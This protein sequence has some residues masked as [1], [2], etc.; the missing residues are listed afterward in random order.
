MSFLSKH[1]EKKQKH[2]VSGVITMPSCVIF[3]QRK[4]LRRIS[5][6]GVRLRHQF[7]Q[8]KAVRW[9][10][11]SSTG[12]ESAGE[13]VLNYANLKTLE[14]LVKNNKILGPYYRS[15]LRIPEMEKIV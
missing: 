14:Y 12:W 9:R 11:L 1:Y 6:P 7:A 15:N 5:S 2:A 10:K 4:I 13:R 3:E 8:Q